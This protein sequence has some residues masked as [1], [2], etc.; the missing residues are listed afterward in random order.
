MEE[1]T[2]SDMLRIPQRP[3]RLLL[4]LAARWLGAEFV[5]NLI[6]ALG[7]RRRGE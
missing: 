6:E 5:F 2:G 1:T 3:F 7:G 4:P